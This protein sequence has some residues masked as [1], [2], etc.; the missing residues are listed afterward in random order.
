MSVDWDR[1]WDYQ[2]DEGWERSSEGEPSFEA[3]PPS[4][5]GDGTAATDGQD[6]VGGV[7]AE[8]T[9]GAFGEPG[10]YV[11]PEVHSTGP[12]DATQSGA[13][14]FDFS[15]GVELSR[16]PLGWTGKPKGRALVKPDEV[17]LAFSPHE[18]LL[19]LDTWQRSG[20]PAGD[21]GDSC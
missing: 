7:D 14:E 18:R 5:E 13:G 16:R 4:F 9:E 10:P 3:D 15:A 12:S 19:I 20:L 8:N 2:G 21:F 1:A 11:D 17:R 6:D